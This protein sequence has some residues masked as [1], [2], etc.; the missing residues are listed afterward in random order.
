MLVHAD[1]CPWCGGAH[2]ESYQFSIGL[3]LP[4]GRNCIGQVGSVP[5]LARAPASPDS[6]PTFALPE[7]PEVPPE[8]TMRATRSRRSVESS[9]NL[10]FPAEV[11][12]TP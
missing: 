10:L 6:H 1:I 3:R 9:F 5:T 8:V 7:I 11:I 4:L 2:A 12:P